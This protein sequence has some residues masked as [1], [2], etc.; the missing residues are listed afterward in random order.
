VSLIRGR[1]KK[2]TDEAVNKY[3]ASLPF[4][5]RLYHYDIAGSIAHAKMLAKQVI[6]SE[7]DKEKILQGLREIEREIEQGQFPFKVE[8]EDIHMAIESRP[9]KIGRRR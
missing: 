1:F 2:E 7:P 8:L 4:D 3:T 9:P 6:I 5:R